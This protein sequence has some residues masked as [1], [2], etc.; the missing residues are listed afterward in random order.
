MWLT[1]FRKECKM[2]GKSL[3]FIGYV[4][5]IIFFYLT[6]MGSEDVPIKPEPGQENYG[7]HYST[8]E[9]VIMETAT[10]SL[11]HEYCYNGYTTYPFAFYKAVQLEE[12]KKADIRELLIELTEKTPEEF[13]SEIEAYKKGMLIEEKDGLLVQADSGPLNLKISENITYDKFLEY[14]KKADKTIGRGSLYSKTYLNSNAREP[15]TY[16]EA[17]QEYQDLMEKD[18]FSGAYARLFCDYFG[19][20]AGII[21]VFFITSR[22]LKDKHSKVSGVIYGKSASS[23]TIVT[24]R[25][26]AVCFMLFLPLLLLSFLP[27]SQ[28]I[29]AAKNAGVTADY[30]AF[31]K[32]CTG[33]LLPCIMFVTAFGYLLGELTERVL[34]ILV[35]VIWWFASLM[36][37]VSHITGSFGFNLIPRF[38]TLGEYNSFRS[39]LGELILNRMIY[40]VAALTLLTAVIYLYECKRK[41]RYIRN[42]KVSKVTIR[43][44]KA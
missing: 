6:Q 23:V 18:R 22:V 44:S 11:L 10:D 5:V 26:T 35:Q 36:A 2:V 30:F 29:Y 40:T 13:D 31:I 38:N 16:E 42:G 32:Y 19:I 4:A 7:Y 20:I 17:L 34:P 33:W 28:A 8:D 1:L 25:Y 39:G 14:M 12:N 21:P 41:G 24:A 37:G 27:L 43:K 9:K 15:L 3:L